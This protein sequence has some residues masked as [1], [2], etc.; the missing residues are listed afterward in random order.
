MG[1]NIAPRI[2]TIRLLLLCGFLRMLYLGRYSNDS[3][4]RQEHDRTSLA[5]L[6]SGVA[7]PRGR[8]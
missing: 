8:L 3:N 2:A 5:F 6:P 7:R 1:R 4:R